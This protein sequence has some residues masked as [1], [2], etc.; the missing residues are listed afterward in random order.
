MKLGILKKSSVFCVKSTKLGS[1]NFTNYYQHII[2]KTNCEIRKFEKVKFF[3]CVK[4]TK[5]G[6]RNFTNYYERIIKKTHGR[7]WEFWRKQMFLCSCV[8]SQIINNVF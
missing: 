3:F 4:S 8:V 5:L 7:N 1:P 2:K 6:I